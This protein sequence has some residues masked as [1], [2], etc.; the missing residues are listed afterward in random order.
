MIIK[1]YI[2][3]DMKEAIIR[4][5]YELGKDAVIISQRNIKVGKWYIPFKQKKLEVTVAVEE[6][7]VGKKEGLRET[8]GVSQYTLNTILDNDILFKNADDSIKANLEYYYRTN[9]NIDPSFPLAEKKTFINTVYSE[10]CFELKASLGKINVFVGPTGVGKTTTIAKIAAKE[11][12]QNEKMVGLI[13]LDTYRIGAVE[14]IKTYA[15]I[16][17]LPCEVVNH[18]DE[19]ERKIKKL[20][21]CDILLIDTLG[22]SQKNQGKLMDISKYLEKVKDEI[23]TY[24]VI[25]I[26]TDCETTMSILE[27]YKMLNYNALILTKFDEANT[28]TN[29]WNFIRNCHYPVQY[30]CTGQDVPDDIQRATL[31]NVI[32]YFQESN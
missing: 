27:K 22:T 23:Q 20:S 28:F 16:L 30:I 6:E 4:A 3:S 8:E 15:S 17:G 26:S 9:P 18:P 7:A 11:Y 1:K 31:D 14:Q 13:T 32:S 2:V 19:M 5:K 10:N 12:L 21:Y 25:N 24:L 29:I